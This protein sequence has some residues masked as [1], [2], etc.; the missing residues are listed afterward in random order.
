M[1]EV[2]EALDEDRISED[3]SSGIRYK[4]LFSERRGIAEADA[5]PAAAD[6]EGI[7]P[8]ANRMLPSESAGAMNSVSEHAAAAISVDAAMAAFH[9]LYIV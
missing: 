2:A 4:V 8:T 7:L 5:E 6:R 9:I 1:S 3:V